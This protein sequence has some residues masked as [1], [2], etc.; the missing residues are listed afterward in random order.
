MSLS[1]SHT[2]SH[3]VSECESHCERLSSA[4]ETAKMQRKH[5]EQFDFSRAFSSMLVFSSM[6]GRAYSKFEQPGLVFKTLLRS[7]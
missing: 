5:D 6:L 7:E 1:V 2:V 4:E 3:T